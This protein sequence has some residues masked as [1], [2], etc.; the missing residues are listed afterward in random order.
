MEDR[1]GHAKP[2]TKT[3]YKGQK[4]QNIHPHMGGRQTLKNKTQT[5]TKEEKH[6]RP[7]I[8]IFGAKLPN[9]NH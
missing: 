8:T 9:D 3:K 2:D 5:Q 6:Y 7:I 1:Q 4:L